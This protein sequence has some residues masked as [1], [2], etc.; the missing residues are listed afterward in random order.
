M[1][2]AMSCWQNGDRLVNAPVDLASGAHQLPHYLPAL[3]VTVAA[4]ATALMIAVVRLRA[5]EI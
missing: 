4:S 3:A 5:R 2:R 1:S